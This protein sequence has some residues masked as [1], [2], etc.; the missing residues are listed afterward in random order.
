MEPLEKLSN[1]PDETYYSRRSSTRSWHSTSTLRRP[2]ANAEQLNQVNRQAVES[3]FRSSSDRLPEYEKE[4]L[5]LCLDR[6]WRY[7]DE[8]EIEYISNSDGSE[9]DDCDDYDDISDIQRRSQN[10]NSFVTLIKP[11]A[12]HLVDKLQAIDFKSINKDQKMFQTQLIDQVS[13]STALVKNPSGQE[14][15]VNTN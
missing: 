6:F 5:K 15:L 14:I 7:A 10:P 8:G 11:R 4:E 2:V 1:N 12:F 9:N 13:R 3:V